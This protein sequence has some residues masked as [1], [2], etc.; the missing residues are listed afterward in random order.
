MMRRSIYPVVWIAL[1]ATF[2]QGLP[3]CAAEIKIMASR[4][5]WTILQ[6]AGPDFE[7]ATGHKLN[8]SVDLAAVVAKRVNDGEAF[9]IAVAA[10]AQIDALVKSGK[11]VADTRTDLTRAGIGIEVRKGAPKPDISTVEAFKKAMLEAKSIGYLK[12]GTS[13]LMV[14]AML[15]RIGLTEAL[16]PKVVLPDDDVVSEMVADGKVEIGMVNISQILTSPGVDLVGPLPP[17]LQSYIVFSGGV[18]ANSK[19]PDAARE[20][21]KFLK[22]PAV[23][24]IKAQ[25]MEP[26]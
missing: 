23:P 6:Q 22:G 8:V 12:A 9:D 15:N 10:P 4:A 24:V 14:A 26:G 5:I 13:G 17:E 18:S 11:L 19:T 16:K 3:T 7:R 2:A 1:F 20:L 21:I 25:G